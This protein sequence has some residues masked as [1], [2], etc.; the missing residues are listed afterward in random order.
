MQYSIGG[1]T[2]AD[3]R[4]VGLLGAGFPTGEH[5]PKIN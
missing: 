2:Q 4:K 5:P 3:I 1:A